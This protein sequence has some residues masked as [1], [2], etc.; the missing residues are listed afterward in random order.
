MFDL[1]ME[2]VRMIVPVIYVAVMWKT[3]GM[4]VG[5]AIRGIRVLREN[6]SSLDWAVEVVCR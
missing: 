1:R 3:K 6:G 2:A 5:A 4:M